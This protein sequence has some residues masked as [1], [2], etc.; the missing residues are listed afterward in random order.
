MTVLW[1]AMTILLL[2]FVPYRAA[3]AGK[4][5]REAGP[6]H[7][8]YYDSNGK[9]FGTAYPDSVVFRIDG[10]TVALK[11]R[12]KITIAALDYTAAELVPQDFVYWEQLGCTGRAILHVATQTRYNSWPGDMWGLLYDGSVAVHPQSGAK[13]LWIAKNQTGLQNLYPQSRSGYDGQ[14]FDEPRVPGI[15]QPVVFTTDWVEAAYPLDQIYQF[16]SF[17]ETFGPLFAK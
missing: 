13:T 9:F 17:V 10:Y 2:A 11:V 16:D 1:T 12:A 5:P 15:D 7:L 6:E 3:Q 4:P 14:C 8:G